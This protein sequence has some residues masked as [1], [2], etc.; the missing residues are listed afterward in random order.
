MAQPSNLL[1]LQALYSVN[2]TIIAV[3]QKKVQEFSSCS[4]HKVVA[5]AGLQYVRIPKEEALRVKEE[6][7]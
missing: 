3:S 2:P 5:S 6:Q 1:E 4:V 7:G